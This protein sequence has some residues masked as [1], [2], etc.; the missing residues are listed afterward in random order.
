MDTSRAQAGYTFG[1]T[2]AF[3]CHLVVVTCMLSIAGCSP[4]TAFTPTPVVIVVSPIASIQA[5][6]AISDGQDAASRAQY[7]VGS[8]GFVWKVE[9]QVLNAE[10]TTLKDASER[11]GLPEDEASPNGAP[12]L[13]V[14]LVVFYGDYQL[15]GP[16]GTLVSPA[17]GCINVVVDASDGT[18]IK[19]TSRTC[20]AP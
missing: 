2:V 9:P 8:A 13:P 17:T 7:S 1:S 11:I 20:E 5:Q 4:R 12:D 18:F 6:G 15:Q 14:W 16:D 10:K 19:L 3:V